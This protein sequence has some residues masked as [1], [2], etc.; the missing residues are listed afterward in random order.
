MRTLVVVGIFAFISLS[1][2]EFAVA[3]DSQF[4]PRDAADGVFD[5]MKDLTGTPEQRGERIHEQTVEDRLTRAQRHA[6]RLREERI[7]REQHKDD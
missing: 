6:A 2:I 7:Y 1:Q 5:R 3:Q 4:T